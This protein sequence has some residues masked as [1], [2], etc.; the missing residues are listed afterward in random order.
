MNDELLTERIE[1]A[2]YHHKGRYG[3]PRIH[4]DLQDEGIFCA[5]KRVARLMREQSLSATRKRRKRST[6]NSNHRFPLA[7][8]LL[9]RNFHAEE[10][11]TKW[12][13]DIT[14]IETK[15]GYLYLSGILDVYSRKIVGWS[16][17]A[18]HSGEIVQSALHMAV[19]ARH[20][21][22]GLIHHSDR[23]SEYAS[24]AYQYLLQTYHIQASMSKKGDCYDNAM[25][26]A[27]LE[28]RER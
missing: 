26:D 22:G 6:T 13:S 21:R 5:R 19:A 28:N 3:S 11:N 17:S 20:P 10:P 15:E 18:H 12:V 7:P 2:Y 25:M 14:Y 4:A 9:A 27:F 23:G 8:N 24:H 1:D 16:M